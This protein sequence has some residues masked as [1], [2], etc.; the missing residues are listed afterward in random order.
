MATDSPDDFVLPTHKIDSQEAVRISSIAPRDRA[1]APPVYLLALPSIPIAV[2][3]YITSTR[4]FQYYHFGMDIFAGMVIGILSAWFSFHWYHMPI[5][6]GAG[7]SWGP[8]SRDRAWGIGVGCGAYVG[9]EGWST[10]SLIETH[11]EGSMVHQTTQTT[12]EGPAQDLI[13][14]TEEDGSMDAQAGDWSMKGGDSAN[15]LPAEGSG[16]ANLSRK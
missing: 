5:S 13:L 9:L 14:D 2:A 7:W 3:V 11:V 8:R 1:A 6:R 4:Y 12:V 16:S 15:V 10:S